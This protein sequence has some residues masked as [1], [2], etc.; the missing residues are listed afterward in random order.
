M[1][2]IIGGGISGLSLGWHLH[3]RNIPYKIFEASNQ[4]GGN[5]KSEKIGN[6][7]IER[8]PN[9]I[10]ADS[11]LIE[12]I[13]E[14][15]LE[16]NILYPQDVSKNRF[17]FKK[18][19]YQKLPAGPAFLVS[20]FFSLQAK[21]SVFREYNKKSQGPENES[22]ADF[23][24][25]RFCREIVEYAVNPFVAGIYAGDPNKLLV[26]KTFPQ[27]YELEKE[28]GSVLKGFLKTRKSTARKVSFSFENGM[29]ELPN[30]MA[31]QVAIEYNSIVIS[32][33]KNEKG[34]FVLSTKNGEV[35]AS[36]I[37]FSIPSFRA[38]T[39][40][41]SISDYSP[42]I[43]KAVPYPKMYVMHTAFK[44]ADMGL[45]PNGF[46]GL[47]P[48]KEGLFTAGSIWSSSLFPSRCPQDEFLF[49]SFVGG[50]QFESQASEPKE[51]IQQKVTEELQK[52]YSIKGQPVFQEL[53][54]W[55]NAIPQYTIDTEAAH[56]ALESFQ[57]VGVYHCTNWKD[58]VSVA[59]CLKKGK[60][61]AEKLAA[62]N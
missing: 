30:A 20:G 22:V 18:G 25:R 53:T 5:I 54:Y 43:F 37:V 35:E 34:S 19:K 1:I 12:I 21:L 32:I 47:H 58:G 36:K 39:F 8:G 27:L 31:K 56:Q 7:L 11:E 55:E 17:I 50:S 33:K 45:E 3:K 41:S 49:T 26:R 61:L 23:F 57:E 60:A 46:G 59:D 28:Y 62:A 44:K 42:N 16:E 48:K 9:S 52:L 10:L 51:E 13:K 14:V 29:Q 15:G 2:A 40:F 38:A 6:Y 4:A 24:E